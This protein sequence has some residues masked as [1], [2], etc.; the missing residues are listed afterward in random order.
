MHWPLHC[1]EEDR[2]NAKALNV[3]EVLLTPTRQVRWLFKEVLRRV[4]TCLAED[5]PLD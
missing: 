4:K 2:G 3:K 1:L 5:E